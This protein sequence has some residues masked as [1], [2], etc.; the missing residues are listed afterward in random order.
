[1]VS[2]LQDAS[3][4]KEV[5]MGVLWALGRLLALPENTV[6]V[7]ILLMCDRGSYNLTTVWLTAQERLLSIAR[8]EQVCCPGCTLPIQSVWPVILPGAPK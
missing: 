1:M 3:T 7:L 5:K 8:A 2:L 6:K 4:P